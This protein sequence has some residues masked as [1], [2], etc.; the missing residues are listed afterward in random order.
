MAASSLVGVLS[1]PYYLGRLGW[2][3][4]LAAGSTVLT[5]VLGVPAAVVFDRYDF[6]GKRLLNIILTLP[7]VVP[8]VVAATA[9]LALLGPGGA[10]GLNWPLGPGLMLA[11][12]TFY[13]YALVVRLTGA[14]LRGFGPR[15]EE[16]ARSLGSNPWRVFW[17][18]TLPTAR[19]GV[20]A[21]AALVFLYCFTSLSVPL[22]LGGGRYNTL[23]AEIYQ[24][25]AYRFRLTEAGSLALM[26]LLVTLAAVLVYVSAQRRSTS[27]LDFVEWRRPPRRG[28]LVWLTVNALIALALTATPLAAL[29]LRS[30][31]VGGQ[32]SLA[33]YA[34][35]F[36]PP[37]G[38]FQVSVAAA[39]VNT[40][41]FAALTLA[42][43][44]PLGVA[45]AVAVWSSRSLA[46]D[47]L[48][49]LPLGVSSV[50][51]GA[52]LIIA[53]PALRASSAILIGAYVLAATPFVARAALPTLRSIPRSQLEAARMLGSSPGQLF[54]RVT[55]PLLRPAVA[56]GA[57]LA[58][59]SVAGEFSS[60]LVLARPEW[61]TLTLLVYDYLGRPG[62]LG[63]AEA[64]SVILLTF[65][66]AC[67]WLLDRGGG[68]FG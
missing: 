6:P 8:L 33:N 10:L 14:F 66:G 2:T 24:L 28:G 57:A 17:R 4:A 38:L 56:A 21:A 26:Q 48:T 40:V 64:L 27:G 51:I 37:T 5:L 53:Y 22:I 59:A 23:E 25:I 9:I 7:F 36:A 68:R 50:T 30:L 3:L 11:A 45:L 35:A 42:V 1:D 15:L 41:G 62:G 58:F 18:V 60:T 63:A 20:L 43:A 13:N 67:F 31:H 12:N 61:T 54:W 46:M 47:A 32:W 52:G 34:R 44:V 39:L 29:L 55:W 19:P 49:L 65:T 16:A